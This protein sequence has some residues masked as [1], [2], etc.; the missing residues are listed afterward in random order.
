MDHGRGLWSFERKCSPEIGVIGQ[1]HIVHDDVFIEPCD[2]PL[3]DYGIRNAEEA[4]GKSISFDFSQNMSLRVQQERDVTRASGEILDVIREYGVEIPHAIWSS[5]GQIGAIVF[6]DE[7]NAVI[8]KAL[9]CAGISP[10]IGQLTTTPRT[11]PCTGVSMKRGER[12]LDRQ[13]S[14]GHC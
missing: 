11:H 13:L 9:F 4:V 8:C 6:V 1:R 12:G 14:F 2:Q 3:A 10:I 5:E 7:R